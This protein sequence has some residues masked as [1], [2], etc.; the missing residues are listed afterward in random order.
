MSKTPPKTP[1]K[2]KNQKKNKIKFIVDLSNNKLPPLNSINY[3]NNRNKPPLELSNKN[4]NLFK[5]INEKNLNSKKNPINMRLDEII[6]KIKKR[7]S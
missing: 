2:K 5:N 6:D 7:K 4:L 1:P 3:L